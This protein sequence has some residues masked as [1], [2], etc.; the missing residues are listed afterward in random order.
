MISS[1]HPHPET[2][3]GVYALLL[4]GVAL[5]LGRR[6]AGWR[7]HT[8]YR[9]ARA[10]ETQQEAADALPPWPHSEIAHFYRGIALLLVLLAGCITAVGLARHHEGADVVVLAPVLVLALLV[11]QR[12]LAAFLALSRRLQ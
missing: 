3:V 12:L 1:G 2:L 8:P 5:G 11:G 6:T 7:R 9:H 10:D 4:L